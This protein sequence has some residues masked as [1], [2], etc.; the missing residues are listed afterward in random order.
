MTFLRNRFWAA[1]DYCKKL[2]VLYAIMLVGFV[3]LCLL[4]H[5]GFSVYYGGDQEAMMRD[6]EGITTGFEQKQIIDAAGQLR[7]RSVFLNNARASALMWLLGALPFLFLPMLIL[8]FNA[9]IVGMMTAALLLMQGDPILIL[10]A[11]LPHGVLE[12]PAIV[13]AAGLG[14][15]L[16]AELIARI[17]RRKSRRPFLLILDDMLW[18]F[19]LF[20]VPLLAAAAL[21]EAYVTP[22]V[23]ALW[24]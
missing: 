7:A 8:A 2:R 14:T 21:I 5:A 13:L 12:I 1:R 17:V 18:S 16:C 3:L 19:V 24:M 4:A 9:L 15:A 11:L 22:L 20:V 10:A 6:I 23:M